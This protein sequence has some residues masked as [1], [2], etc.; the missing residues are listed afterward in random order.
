MPKTDS[1]QSAPKNPRPLWLLRRWKS[2]A[3][4]LAGWYIPAAPFTALQLYGPPRTPLRER[5]NPARLDS[6]TESL[7]GRLI[8]T[9]EGLA[10]H[11]GEAALVIDLPGAISVGLGFFLQELG[12]TPVLLFNGLYRPESL[13]EGK[14]SLP[15]IIRYGTRLQ[16]W[17]GQPGYA[18]LLERERTG[19]EPTGE[20]AFW[21]TFDNRYHAGDHL[22]PPFEKLKESGVTAFIDLRLAG[23]ELPNDVNRFYR[24]AARAGFDVFQAALPADW[25]VEP[26]NPSPLTTQ[27][28]AQ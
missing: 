14:N 20:L 19:P 22:F 18:F 9:D 24:A 23:D 15:A 8:Q 17:S 6:I 1:Y 28:S 10:V 26:P 11:G 4:P 2:A 16:T 13:V 3:G 7:A 27:V 5:L 25:L 12:I 21:R